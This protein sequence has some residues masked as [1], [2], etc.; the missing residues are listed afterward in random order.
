[1]QKENPFWAMARGEAEYPPCA[2]TLGWSLVA[3]EPGRVTIEFYARPEF[4]NPL[5][6]VQGGFIVAMLDDTLG[7]AVATT[8]E[9][10]QFAP[11]LEIKAS[12]FRPAK[13]GKLIARGWV[14][15]R[16][17]SIVFAEG[18]IHDEAGELIARASATTRVVR[19]NWVEPA[20]P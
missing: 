19:A 18:E 16:G 20:E 5:G 17:R 1:M 9:H 14:V 3:V 8:L 10:D 6:N 12:F 2:K 4:A 13:V 15:Q 7:P 11:T